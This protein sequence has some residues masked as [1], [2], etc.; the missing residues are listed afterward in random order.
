MNLCTQNHVTLYMI[1]FI[2][3]TICL[4]YFYICFYKM[5]A[6]S[7]T[8]EIISVVTE[9]VFCLVYTPVFYNHNVKEILVYS[10]YFFHIQLLCFVCGEIIKL[11]L[12]Y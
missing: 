7:I 10:T 2:I 1:K 9:L 12:L 8:T 5:Q 3:E 11:L 6:S 4:P